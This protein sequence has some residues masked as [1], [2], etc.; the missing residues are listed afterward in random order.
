MFSPRAEGCAIL[1]MNNI[2]VFGGISEYR[3]YPQNIEVYSI[4]SDTWNILNV[5][6]S[7][8]QRLDFT[9]ESVRVPSFQ[10]NP[11]KSSSSVA[12]PS[13]KTNNKN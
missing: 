1:F 11:T 8:I 5:N 13:H 2:Y 3:Q 9:V 10:I 12:S 6:S 4:K 7:H